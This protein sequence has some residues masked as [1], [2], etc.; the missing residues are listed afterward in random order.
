M[1]STISAATLP[2]FAAAR[3]MATAPPNDLPKTATCMQAHL[4]GG[5]PSVDS[6]FEQ[7]AD[8]RRSCHSQAAV[9][10]CLRQQ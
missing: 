3:C 9:P 1:F 5:C 2:G 4:F 8:I 10:E 7:L 6:M